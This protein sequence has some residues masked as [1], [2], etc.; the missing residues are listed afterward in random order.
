[1]G[2]SSLLPVS[3]KTPPDKVITTP[4]ASSF[5]FANC[6]KLLFCLQATLLLGFELGTGELRLF[7]RLFLLAG[8]LFQGFLSVGEL[9]LR[10]SLVLLTRFLASLDR[11]LAVLV[12]LLEL[13]GGMGQL[14]F[15]FGDVRE[16]ARRLLFAVFEGAFGCLQALFRR[17]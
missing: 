5:T 7:T 10:C 14:G 17:L 16:V 8:R 12:G 13:T 6:S 15:A 4:R 1:M 2:M 11:R 9:A 3:N